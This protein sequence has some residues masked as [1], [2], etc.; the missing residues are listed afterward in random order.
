MVRKFPEDLFE[1]Y[2]DKPAQFVYRSTPRR[3]IIYGAIAVIGG[4][5]FLFG[6]GILFPNVVRIIAL[7]GMIYAVYMLVYGG[8]SW[9]NLTSGQRI[10]PI[11]VKH[12]ARPMKSMPEGGE[13]DQRIHN[14]FALNDWAALASEPS[15]KGN[16][17]RLSIHEDAVGRIFYLQLSRLHEYERQAVGVS[18]VKIVSAQE[19]TLNHSVIKSIK[20][21]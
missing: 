14:M 13:E 20:S 5:I 18:D 15:E 12:F 21:T 10:I 8:R 3:R 1:Y 4:M 19:Y 11:A 16:P 17:M 7:V 6:R 9:Y 2:A